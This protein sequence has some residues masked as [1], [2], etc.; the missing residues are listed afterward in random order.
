MKFS[1]LDSSYQAIPKGSNFIF[2][3]LIDKKIF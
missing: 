2:L 3:E 1:L